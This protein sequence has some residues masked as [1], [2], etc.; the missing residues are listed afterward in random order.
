[1]KRG[2][3][4]Y[5]FLLWVAFSSGCASC[6]ERA[7]TGGKPAGESC[8]SSADCLAGL[9][10]LLGVCAQQVH[11]AGSGDALTLDAA[12]SDRAA[13][14]QASMDTQVTPD[15]S[16]PDTTQHP[17]LTT[18]PDLATADSTVA[19]DVPGPAD[20]TTA[21]T[22]SA[23]DALV[24]GDVDTSLC[25]AQLS[26]STIELG[27]VLVGSTA[28]ASVGMIDQGSGPCVLTEIQIA[29][30]GAALTV[31]E[32]AALPVVV[33]PL[34]GSGQVETLRLLYAPTAP[35]SL[36]ATVTARL[37]G[38]SGGS[39][40]FLV[41]ATAIATPP[42]TCIEFSTGLVDFGSLP[43]Q[44]QASQQVLVVNACQTLH[45]VASL[46]LTGNPAFTVETSAPFDV[47]AGSVM[48]V[49]LKVQLDAA[50]MATARLSATLEGGAHIAGQV[51]LI[52][53]VADQIEDSYLQGGNDPVD[54]F[55]VVDDSGS[56][57]PA[58]AQLARDMSALINELEWLGVSYHIGVTTTDME[59][60]VHGRFI[61]LSETFPVITPSS[62][63]NPTARL[64]AAVTPGSSGSGTE[65]G[66]D[67]TVAALS[68]PL[69]ATRNA[70]FLRPEALLAV[71]YLSNE[72][73]QSNI[74]VED[75]LTFLR[76]LKGH[77]GNNAISVGALVTLEGDSCASATDPGT[78]FLALMDQA[79]GVRAS[80]CA[81][82]WTPLLRE[83]VRLGAGQRATFFLSSAA[84]ATPEV[85]VDGVLKTFGVDFAYD[86][87]SHSVTFAP[88]GVP[89]PGQVV[90]FRYTSRCP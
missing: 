32:P 34:L 25:S 62:L 9:R 55:I 78:R 45:R 50:G 81:A 59:T 46:T 36:S 69:S 89:L 33:Q 42:G 40:T 35:G 2:S 14:D 31:L 68:L 66:F 88:G 6:V 47:G 1:M 19:S 86:S 51:E 20:A 10:C 79:S 3:A 87:G 63:P 64:T 24:G 84:Q 74:S 15:A 52:A 67:A 61:P 7:P 13:R 44:C 29:P 17:D 80:I 48:P 28:S 41:T 54:L 82:D 43:M 4:L 71:L 70:G 72:E 53:E 27:T 60:G 8:L 83:L 57:D 37:G 65:R 5:F 26:Q 77:L 12:A 18:G 21:D 56:M 38:T 23:T 73:E 75:T 49:Q 85:R 11:D 90:T 22:T 30:A 16:R 76:G 39:L 58:Q